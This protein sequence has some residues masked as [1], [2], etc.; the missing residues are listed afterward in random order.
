MLRDVNGI[1]LV[2]KPQGA[3]SNEVLQFVK[4]LFRA[5]KAGHTGSLDPI[6][7]GMLPICFGFA[8]KFS[9]FLLNADKHY[10]VT[11]KLGEITAS[12]DREG[13][14][15]AKYEVT[16]IDAHAI[17]NILPKFRGKVLQTPPM[18]SVL[19]HKGQPLYKLA[20]QGITVARHPREIT[21]YTLQ[22]LTVNGE[23]FKLVMRCSKGTYVRTVVSDIGKMLGCGAHVTDLRRLAVGPYQAGAM[24]PLAE[25]QKLSYQEL[26]KFL[27]PLESMLTNM[28][29]LILARD[30]ICHIQQGQPLL[31]PNAPA[32]GWIK[33][34]D[35][36]GKFLGVGEIMPDGKVNPRKIINAKH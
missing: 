34:V 24:L 11:G 12:E 30:M 9:Q 35:T 20:R 5:K 19:K 18:Y 4:R 15:V 1:L 36:T 17:E 29:Q 16:N 26:D 10:I 31:L 33:I 14:V 13:E 3:T 8:T 27:L 32:S 2:D 21:I 23:F 25:L 28:P 6:A 7:T 22:L